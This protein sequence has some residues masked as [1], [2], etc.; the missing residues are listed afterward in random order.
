[1]VR[2]SRPQPE[3]VKESRGFCSILEHGKEVAENTMLLGTGSA[4]TQ[5]GYPRD[6]VSARAEGDCRDR[7]LTAPRTSLSG[8]PQPGVQPGV[9]RHRPNS[10][11]PKGDKGVRSQ[12][13]VHVAPEA[14]CLAENLPGG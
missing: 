5:P 13:D 11:W 1:M 6:S 14:V 8:N 7:S 3:R 12:K 2:S 4:V 10:Q 9:E